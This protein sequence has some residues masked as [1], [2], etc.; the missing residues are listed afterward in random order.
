MQFAVSQWTLINGTWAQIR[1]DGT[2]T[3]VDT[4]INIKQDSYIVIAVRNADDSNILPDA[5][6][7]TVDILGYQ[8]MAFVNKKMTESVIA[9]K[10]L[11]NGFEPLTE[12]GHTVS[13]RGMPYPENTYFAFEKCIAE[14]SKVLEMDLAFTS[15]NVAVLLHDKTI[16]RTGRNADGTSIAETIN[17]S[18]ITYEQALEYD[19]GIYMGSQYAGLK[20]PKL[21][22][23]LLLLRWKRCAGIIDLL[24]HE[25]TMEQYQILHDILS[26]TAMTTKCALNAQTSQLNAYAEKYTDTPFN[27]TSSTDNI[28]KLKNLYNTYK[29]VTPLVI[30]SGYVEN[31]DDLTYGFFK[32]A[33]KLGVI[34]ILGMV[35]TVQEIKDLF[36]AG[37]SLVYS[38]TIRDSDLE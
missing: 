17:I 7:V 20:I 18:D 30:A 31:A 36:N 28:E 34:T 19:F 15:D 38:E 9:Q 26:G 4:V 35:N 1:N 8:T 16:N 13:H 14:G 37:C 22:D 29:D 27:P 3:V 10:Q 24:G 25:Y 33:N 21:I 5:V 6:T 12:C 32:E 11:L 23:V 2:F